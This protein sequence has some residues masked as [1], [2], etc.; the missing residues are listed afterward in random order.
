LSPLARDIAIVLVVKALALGALW[1]AFFRM[2][3]A[4]PATPG[5]KRVEQHV[6]APQTPPA[7]ALR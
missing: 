7:H 6:V 5:A 3:D 2:P 4:D 1:L